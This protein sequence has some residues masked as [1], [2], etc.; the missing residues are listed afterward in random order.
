MTHLEKKRERMFDA[1]SAGLLATLHNMEERSDIDRLMTIKHYFRNNA[2]M[3]IEH[4]AMA[5]TM[6]MNKLLERRLYMFVNMARKLAPRDVSQLRMV[7]F[8]RL[9]LKEAPIDWDRRT[10]H[11]LA[12]E[13]LHMRVAS[14]C[15]HMLLRLCF[16]YHEASDVICLLADVIWY[17]AYSI[18][19]SVM[20]RGLYMQFHDIV[21]SFDDAVPDILCAERFAN[22]LIDM[23]ANIASVREKRI[24]C[25]YDPR[26]L[27]L[28]I[29]L[30]DR[31][32]INVN[33]SVGQDIPFELFTFLAMHFK[34][35][36]IAYF[37]RMTFGNKSNYN[38]FTSALF[39]R[40]RFCELLG[41]RSINE[42]F[43]L[44]VFVESR[45]NA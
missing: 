10:C 16:D 22:V 4:H 14:D 31:C 12:E 36:L 7:G 6:S 23:V 15:M 9:F 8:D 40:S 25:K 11:N 42:R 19:T 33:K 44:I 28:R 17:R 34:P 2:D 5:P 37:V 27:D 29:E 21:S 30:R 18:T 43:W 32:G 24:D 3:L 26:F 39:A 35:K 41:H 38:A 45:A 20:R 1:I 13:F